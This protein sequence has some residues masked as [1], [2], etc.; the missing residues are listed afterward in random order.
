M[1]VGC[2]VVMR[3][4]CHFVMRVV[5]HFVM[6]VVCHFVMRVVCYFVMRVGCHFVM[7]V[8]CYFVMRVVCHFVMRVGCHFVMRVVCY[9][10]MR[11]GCHFVMRVQRYI[12]R[13]SRSCSTKR[14][15]N[16]REARIKA[17]CNTRCTQTCGVAIE[18]VWQNQVC[19]CV[20][21]IAHER[22]HLCV[23]KGWGPHPHAPGM[24]ADCPCS[25]RSVF[26][27]CG[28]RR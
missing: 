28:T 12:K 11:V 25:R 19:V 24:R 16:A 22:A 2:H 14:R 20:C 15:R 21:V 6:R 17:G 23:H 18:L 1:K 7:R 13:D 10:V 4:V 27:H 5:C 26:L 3:V 8:V 9:F